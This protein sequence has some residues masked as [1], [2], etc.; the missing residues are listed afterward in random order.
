MK[1]SEWKEDLLNYPLLKDEIIE[2]ALALKDSIDDVNDKKWAAF[3]WRHKYDEYE[4]TGCKI[5]Y[6]LHCK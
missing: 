3:S 6:Y 4:S 2:N 5:V 1:T